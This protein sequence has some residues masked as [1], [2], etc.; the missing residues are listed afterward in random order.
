MSANITTPTNDDNS[1]TLTT[2]ALF[3][4]FTDSNI[5]IIVWFLAIYFAVYL[6]L[7]IIRGKEGANSS[8]SRWID[9]VALICV[10]IYLGFTFF[11]KTEEEK[12]A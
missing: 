8:M 6:L 3:Q 11:D 5:V 10:L 4:I 2:D 1:S 9:I 7:N 12:Q